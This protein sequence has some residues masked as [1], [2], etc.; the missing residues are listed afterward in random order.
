MIGDSEA[1]S[2]SRPASLS[3]IRVN[4][5]TSQAS[6]LA[7]TISLVSKTTRCNSASSRFGPAAALSSSKFDTSVSTLTVVAIFLLC[8]RTNISTSKS[9]SMYSLSRRCD[10]ISSLSMRPA[11]YNTKT[12]ASKRHCRQRIIRP[13]Y[14]FN[15]PS[16]IATT[17]PSLSFTMMFLNFRGCASK[18]SISSKYRSKLSVTCHRFLFSSYFNS[19]NPSRRMPSSAKYM[20]AWF[21]AV[22][23][24]C[25]PFMRFTL[26]YSE[27]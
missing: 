27:I 16:S 5:S 8:L 21:F 15:V 12:F 20:S 13:P 22:T 3:P 7:T 24:A 17:S 1:A 2:D 6:V 4:P 14:Y 9:S 25:N 19:S 23:T 26:Q 11:T 10:P 18:I